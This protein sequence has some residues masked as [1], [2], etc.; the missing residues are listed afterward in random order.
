M[1]ICWP[2]PTEPWG[3]ISICVFTGSLGGSDAELKSETSAIGNGVPLSTQGV[4]CLV[5]HS[6][7][8]YP[9]SPVTHSWT[10]FHWSE[11]SR[12]LQAICNFLQMRRNLEAGRTNPVPPWTSI[13]SVQRPPAPL[14]G[15]RH[16]SVLGRGLGSPLGLRGLLLPSHVW[17][18]AMMTRKYVE[19]GHRFISRAA[20]PGRRLTKPHWY[21]ASTARAPFST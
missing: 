16:S 4:K 10:S 15:Q 3:R 5:I 14:P 20:S 7:L 13:L 19:L 12:A 1:P 9:G 17:A 8:A 21:A 11:T 2:H 18:T 6:L